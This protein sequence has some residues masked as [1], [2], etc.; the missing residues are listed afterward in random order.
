MRVFRIINI[1]ETEIYI[2]KAL[3]SETEI[4]VV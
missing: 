1:K 2:A 4:A 3:V